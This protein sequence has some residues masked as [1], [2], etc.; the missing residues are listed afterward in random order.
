MKTTKYL[1]AIFSIAGKACVS[2]VSVFALLPFQ[3]EADCAHWDVSG[4]WGLKQ[5]DGTL[6]HMQLSQSASSNS[7]SGNA[8][9]SDRNHVGVQ[10]G[11]TEKSTKPF[12]LPVPK[13]VRW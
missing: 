3:A 4:N 12:G 11:G 8:S 1:P 5:S 6:V 10:E 7:V 9:Y 13:W 2:L